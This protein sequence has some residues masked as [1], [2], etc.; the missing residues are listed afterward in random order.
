MDQVMHNA[1]RDII[2]RLK[3]IAVSLGDDLG[4][5]GLYPNYAIAGN[6]TSVEDFWGQ[7]HVTRLR[8]IRKV[9]DPS[10]VMGLAGGWR[11]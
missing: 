8:V 1:A 5:G 11:V 4:E 9:Y 2:G 10:N 7:E 6:G 3:A